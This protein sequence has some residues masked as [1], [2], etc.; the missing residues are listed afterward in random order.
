MR[1]EASPMSPLPIDPVEALKPEL[2]VPTPQPASSSVGHAY[3][4][5]VHYCTC[6]GT[7][8]E[9]GW[10]GFSCEECPAYRQV[11]SNE[12]PVDACAQLLGAVLQS[13]KHDLERGLEETFWEA[14]AFVF[15][16]SDFGLLCGLLNLDAGAVRQAHWERLAAPQRKAITQRWGQ[17][18]EPVAE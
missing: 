3:Y 1:A 5:C 6:L 11:L 12:I 7:A 13:A 4:D 10:T 18:A 8:A 2:E 15:R 9:Q 17:W 14:A 16:H